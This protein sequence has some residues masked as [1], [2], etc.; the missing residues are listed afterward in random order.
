MIS[1]WPD[2]FFGRFSGLDPYVPSEL[3]SWLMG[4]DVLFVLGIA[5]FLGLALIVTSAHDANLRLAQA[6]SPRREIDLGEIRSY[7]SARCRQAKEDVKLLD[8]RLSSPDFNNIPTQA[9]Y[10]LGYGWE[11][12][13]AGI[14][15]QS[16]GPTG[17][18]R[19][20]ETWGENSR[21]FKEGEAANEKYKDF[22]RRAPKTFSKPPPPSTA[23]GSLADFNR[24]LEEWKTAP[25]YTYATPE[26]ERLWKLFEQRINIQRTRR[27]AYDSMLSICYPTPDPL[28]DLEDRVRKLEQQQK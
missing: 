18:E 10:D 26:S 17:R 28:Q 8:G 19:T 3:C 4:R 7:D 11:R 16:S 20:L 13:G 25:S 2:E 27:V 23:G 21:Q 9:E 14:I 12:P 22:N 1:V 5:G 6:P 24:R 15:F